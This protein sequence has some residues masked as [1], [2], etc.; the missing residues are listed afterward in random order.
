MKNQEKKANI[1]RWIAR[2]WGSLILAFVLFFIL[3]YMFGAERLGLENLSNRDIIT[4][5]FFPISSIIVYSS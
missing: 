4:F 3:G 1:I 5:I 2:V